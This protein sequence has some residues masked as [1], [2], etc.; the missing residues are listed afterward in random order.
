[1]I[2]DLQTAIIEEKKL[3]N[4]SN[5]DLLSLF[6][7]NGDGKISFDEFK[8]HCL[9]F[10]ISEK[11]RIK[12]DKCLNMLFNFL[13]KD[14]NG[15]LS[16]LEIARILELEPREVLQPPPKIADQG[17]DCFKTYRRQNAISKFKNKA[18]SYMIKNK[19]NLIT[20]FTKCNLI[21]NDNNKP[22]LINQSDFFRI[23][24]KVLEFTD[25]QIDELQWIFIEIDKDQSG[26]I[27]FE[28]LT[29]FLE[30][31]KEL[32]LISLPEFHSNIEE[33]GLLSLLYGYSIEKQLPLSHLIDEI[34]ADKDGS[35]SI[36]E[37]FVFMNSILGTKNKIISTEIFTS[38]L[39]LLKFKNETELEIE[40]L[41]IAFSA[42]EKYKLSPREI[43]K[44]QKEKII[45]KIRD[46]LRTGKFRLRLS[47]EYEEI[48]QG[49]VKLDA[50][51]RILLD[52]N[53]SNEEEI[54]LVINPLSLSIIKYDRLNYNNFLDWEEL[55]KEELKEIERNK[56]TSVIIVFKI[57]KNI[58]KKFG[59]DKYLLFSLLDRQNTGAITQENMINAFKEIGLD[60]DPQAVIDAFRLIDTSEDGKIDMREFLNFIKD[61]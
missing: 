24:Q 6:D 36:S 58:S 48:E 38:F 21:E 10:N 1:M 39:S 60:F 28:E 3:K 29:S 26:D 41:N 52:S 11:S 56:D 18:K 4:L 19:L 30:C 9:K 54:S 59:Y 61:I 15:D 16:L 35:V 43:S 37:L 42:F 32:A 40:S 8:N 31:S 50:F 12:S 27:S 57:L 13:D 51:K 14:G 46:I 45:L 34:D 22:M 55:Y 33:D 7:V 44:E 49:K 20:F 5:Y 53:K 17:L 2:V 25:F 47:F 23:S